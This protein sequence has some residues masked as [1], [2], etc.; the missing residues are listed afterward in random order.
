MSTG[1]WHPSAAD[2]DHPHS[3][4]KR[5]LLP[6]SIAA[7]CICVMAAFGLAVSRSPAL[8]LTGVAVCWYLTC[9]RM[10]TGIVLLLMA[11]IYRLP[12]P[13][14]NL[15]GLHTVDLS[16]GAIL[17]T[18]ALVVVRH[19]ALL[20]RATVTQWLLAGAVAQVWADSISIGAA[21]SAGRVLQ[22]VTLAVATAI[23][24]VGIANWLGADRNGSRARW[25]ML[26]L[27]AAGTI[28]AVQALMLNAVGSSTLAMATATTSGNVTRLGGV[29]GNFLPV[30]LITGVAALLLARPVMLY[31]RLLASISI[32]IMLV[33]LYLT[34]T[35][36]AYIDLLDVLLLI[37]LTAQTKVRRGWR[38]A[39]VLAI[40]LLA[41][42]VT[43]VTH[44]A[45][46]SRFEELSASTNSLTD[47][48]MLWKAALHIWS[49]SPIVG[50]GAGSFNKALNLYYFGILPPSFYTTFD[51]PEQQLLGLMCETGLVGLMSYLLGMMALIVSGRRTL[52]SRKLPQASSILLRLAIVLAVARLLSEASGT[53]LSGSMFVTIPLAALLSRYSVGQ[54]GYAES[55][56]GSGM[57]M[58]KIDSAK[59][60]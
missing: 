30:M 1:M 21:L 20:R 48:M 60:C 58:D 39:M 7:L 10:K 14:I 42:S 41:V 53:W 19:S 35:R 34:Y 9:G 46:V 36:G 15:G 5:V 50:I 26:A 38:V 17:A 55:R 52:G 24:I 33:A 59:A 2:A 51:Y 23:I 27:G 28:A 4:S 18:A 47:R 13:A 57:E 43:L 16:Q 44:A 56:A 3:R 11:S 49:V 12:S 25:F 29:A 6:V 31:H 8:T 22:E 54:T 40:A 37:A 45:I 32:V